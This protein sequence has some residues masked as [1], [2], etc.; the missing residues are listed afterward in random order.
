[1]V[2]RYG[3][4]RKVFPGAV[5]DIYLLDI[6]THDTPTANHWAINASRISWRPDLLAFHTRP[7]YPR[8]TRWVT[9]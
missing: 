7:A 1:M 8:C 6:Q 5:A 4:Y 3:Q 2:A 9:L